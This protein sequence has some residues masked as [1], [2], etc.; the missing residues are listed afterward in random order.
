MWGQPTLPNAVPMPTPEIQY[1]DSSGRPLSGSKLCTYAAGS[2]TPLATYTS[3]TAGTPNTNPII[4]DTAGRASVWVGPAL[5]KFVLRTGGTPTGCNDGSIVWTQDNVADTTLYF[6]NY[7]KTVGTATLIT[8]VIPATGG[9]SQTVSAKLFQT[10]NVLDF[11]VLCNG[12]ANDTTG[13]QAAMD[14][15]TSKGAIIHF[16]AGTCKYAGGITL[17]PYALIIEGSG[18]GLP[19]GWYTGS[20]TPSVSAANPGTILWNTGSGLAFIPPQADTG[21]TGLEYGIRDIGFYNGAG[22]M[23]FGNLDYNLDV[24]ISDVAVLHYTGIAFELGSS[25]G[26]SGGNSQFFNFDRCFFYDGVQAI[27]NHW[28]VDLAVTHTNF[29]KHSGFQVEIRGAN[30]RYTEDT[31]IGLG[32]GL[33]DV[34]IWPSDA[35]PTSG[36]PYNVKLSGNKFGNEGDSVGEQRPKVSIGTAA[37]LAAHPTFYAAALLIQGNS[38]IC[39]YTDIPGATTSCID[40][41]NPLS[42]SII[43]GNVFLNSTYAVNDALLTQSSIANNNSYYGNRHAGGV[44]PFKAG[45]SSFSY[46]E[47]NESGPQAT[48]RHEE[49]VLAENAIG[50]SV[51]FTLWTPFA[52]NATVCG[53]ADPFGGTSA[54]TLSKTAAASASVG[55]GGA[56]TTAGA[57]V[58]SVWLKAGS[59]S[60]VT[61][62]ITDDMDVPLAQTYIALDSI[63]RRY[64]V[65]VAN[66]SS[67]V[68]LV[69]VILPGRVPDA[70]AGTILAYGGQLQWGESPGDY[71]ETF[72]AVST[73][74]HGRSFKSARITSLT[75]DD[76]ATSLNHFANYKFC[77]S[78]TGVCYLF[79]LNNN[80]TFLFR[81]APD[82][83][84]YDTFMT[85]DTSENVVFGKNVTA[86]QMKADL[87]LILN[88]VVAQPTCVSGLRGL[89]WVIQGGG[90]VADILQVCLKNSGGSYVWV[91]K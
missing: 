87:G 61:L 26:P 1:L 68:D 53:V 58:F 20:P 67:G 34:L 90:G 54:C 43:S 62:R 88:T 3:S 70:V 23:K 7:V 36:G 2:S 21:L 72:N 75:V 19:L 89:M 40:I 42:D 49:R 16:P 78:L 10:I 55:A 73:P 12:T 6:A 84:T 30:T 85:V 57:Q 79:T 91:T 76:N 66:V 5:Y 82:G 8:Y 32:T 14:S 52:M 38:F 48:I 31:F 15:V 22:V 17:P 74:Y 83:V 71:V 77:E 37:Q 86:E 9:V 51:D 44:I 24:T 50:V 56:T 80:G 35:A 63:W 18:Y 59:L 60:N 64:S 27:L 25:D 29:W 69:G 41:Y 13:I 46:I 33:G 65:R 45:G 11:G 39:P 28:N 4:L 81:R 47:G